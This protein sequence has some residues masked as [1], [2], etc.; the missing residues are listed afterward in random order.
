MK[1]NEKLVGVA[2]KVDTGTDYVRR[3]IMRQSNQIAGWAQVARDH[4]APLNVCVVTIWH[5]SAKS[6]RWVTGDATHP[7][8]LSPGRPGSLQ[9]G[10]ATL[11]APGLCSLHRR[12]VTA[13]MLRDLGYTDASRDLRY[14]V[15][16][17]NEL[18]LVILIG[19][20][21]ELSHAVVPPPETNETRDIILRS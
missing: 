18:S 10:Q 7:P 4:G 19:P 15:R 9:P 2:G 5:P 17:E 1:I 6:Y 21:V 20:R 8:G 11:F 16:G 14:E 3:W 13:D 12:E